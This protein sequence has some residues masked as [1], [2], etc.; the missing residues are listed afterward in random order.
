MPPRKERIPVVLDTNVV[1]SFFLS[2]N[3]L[4]ASARIFKLWFKQRKLQLIVSGEIIVEYVEVLLRLGVAEKRVKLFNEVLQKRATVT[5]VNLGARPSLSRDPD[6]NIFLATAMAG[7][8]GFLV[9]N[10]KDLLDIPASQ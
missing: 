6:D 10:D 4:S 1:V 3:L 8:A 9:T 7:S 5:R 2:R